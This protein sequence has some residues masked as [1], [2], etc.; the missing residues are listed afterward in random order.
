MHLNTLWFIAVAVLFAGYFMLEGFDFGVGMLLPFLGGVTKEEKAARR[1]AAIRAIGPLRDG[2]GVWLNTAGCA[3]FAAFPEWYA[4]MFSG[5][6]LPLLLILVSLIL[7]GVG[8]EWR[9]KVDTQIWRDRCDIGIA[10]GC[11]VP[12]LL[13]GIA[14][15]IIARGVPIDGNRQIDSGIGV[16]FSLLNPVGLL[17]GLAFVAVFMLH[18]AMFLGLKTTAPL[19]SHV[20]SFAL[21]FVAITAIIL[22]AG[23]GLWVQINIGKPWTWVLVAL[24]AAG[25]IGGVLA[26]FAG[27]DGGAFAATCFAVLGVV[28]LLFGSLFP[29]LMPTSLTDGTSLTIHNASS[30]PYTLKVMTW[31][32]AFF[33]PLVIAYQAWTYWGFRKR[34]SA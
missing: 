5:F 17:G 20:H 18:G 6:Y 16:P 29:Q 23:F 8:L 34:V 32:A 14:F 9:G 1:S 3:L 10:I 13:W 30:T 26:M 28:A 11:W 22:A 25:L 21:K 31:A 24:I 12:A 7:R 33:L 19:R 27:R 2:N 4:T 15:A